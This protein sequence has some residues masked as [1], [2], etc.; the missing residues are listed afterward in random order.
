MSR[1]AKLIEKYKE[2]EVSEA[3]DVKEVIKALI[4]AKP[5]DDNKD[6]GAFSQMIKGMS[7]SDDPLSDKFMM[8]LM[9]LIST[10]NFG[11]LIK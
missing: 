7:F 2:L 3:V 8:K 5:S 10:E 4:D 9:E 11:D 6:Q 1:C